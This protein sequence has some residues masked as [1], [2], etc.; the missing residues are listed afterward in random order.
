MHNGN[1]CISFI[2]TMSKNATWKIIFSVNKDQI[3]IEFEDWS[4]IF[5]ER[6]IKT[7]VRFILFAYGMRHGNLF[8]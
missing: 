5:F 2:Y 4:N 3:F 1:V 8:S 7:T 6:T